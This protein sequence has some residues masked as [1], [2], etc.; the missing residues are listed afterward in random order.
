MDKG[1]AEKAAEK[2]KVCITSTTKKLV[3]ATEAAQSDNA[4][5]EFLTSR[6]LFLLTYDTNLNFDPLVRE[7]GLGDAITQ[8]CRGVQSARSELY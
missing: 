8:V 2:L 3:G 6:I 4:D 5:D 7:K 1:H